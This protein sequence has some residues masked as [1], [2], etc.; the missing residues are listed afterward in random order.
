M[1]QTVFQD[2]SEC[3]ASVVKKAAEFPSTYNNHTTCLD[4]LHNSSQYRHRGAISSFYTMQVWKL[5]L[6][7][8]KSPK[9][10]HLC[11]DQ[12]EQKHEFKRGHW[13]LAKKKK[14][15]INWQ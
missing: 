6:G 13:H 12:L 10:S 5:C 15:N 7:S 8:M 11:W 4:A 9:P 14:K 2:V 3:L 1:A